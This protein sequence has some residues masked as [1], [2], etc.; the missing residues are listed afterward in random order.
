LRPPFRD[1]FTS[2]ITGDATGGR[3]IMSFFDKVKSGL[4]RAQHEI[5]EFAATTKL[6]MEISKLESQK[7]E[8]LA[9]IGK[10]V[11]EQRTQGTPA[12]VGETQ[13]KEVDD[14]DRQIK[15]KNDEMA[16]LL[17]DT[18]PDTAKTV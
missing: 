2:H 6:K 13:C 14:L 15:A 16:K 1:R 18:P 5:N 9:Q 12:S 17:I 3:D 11:Y 7:N 10:L 4:D 8:L